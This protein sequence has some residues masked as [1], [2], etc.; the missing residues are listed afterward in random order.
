MQGTLNFAAHQLSLQLAISSR[1]QPGDSRKVN[2]Y[3]IRREMNFRKHIPRIQ[4]TTYNQDDSF[5][6]KNP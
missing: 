5:Y 6:K 4:P 3:R 2:R 1:Q